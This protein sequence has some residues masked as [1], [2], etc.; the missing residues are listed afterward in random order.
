MNN[1]IIYKLTCLSNQ[2]F[3]YGSTKNIKNRMR[4]Y[5][6]KLKKGCYGNS[7]LQNIYNKHGFENLKWEVMQESIPDDILIHV[8][9]IWIGAN[10]AKIQDKKGGI[11]IKGASKPSFSQETKDLLSK[12]RKGRPNTWNKGKPMSQEQK[13][14]ISKVKLSKKYKPSEETKIKLSKASKNKKKSQEFINKISIAVLQYDLQNNFITEWQSATKVG[15]N[16]KAD[17]TSF[18]QCCKGKQK[19]AYG[20]IWKY[21]D[22]S[23]QKAKYG[24][25]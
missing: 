6:H 24:S 11:N 2:Y 4:C 14:L 9:D 5:K 21:K 18:T 25:K 19:T 1:G 12:V 15:E 22:E 17:S 7:I 3:L 20:Y 13:N 23:L 10:C 8:E 16:F